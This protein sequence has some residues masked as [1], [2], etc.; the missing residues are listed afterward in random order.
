MLNQWDTSTNC[1]LKTLF[2]YL[3]IAPG[4]SVEEHHSTSPTIA[5][6]EPP[7]LMLPQVNLNTIFFE[8]DDDPPDPP[9]NSEEDLS[10]S[11]PKPIGGHFSD[12]PDQ[13]SQLQ[14]PLQTHRMNSI[15]PLY[16]L[17]GLGRLPMLLVTP[18]LSESQVWLMLK[19]LQVNLRLRISS[20][21]LVTENTLGEL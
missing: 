7:D 12:Y 19:D 5:E 11:P 2:L 17:A 18:L 8:H 13:R 6:T 9:Q 20:H 3:K 21:S 15:P 10:G 4:C 14:F 1:H 16:V